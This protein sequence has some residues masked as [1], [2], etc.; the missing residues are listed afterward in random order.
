MATQLDLQTSCKMSSHKNQDFAQCF[1]FTNHFKFHQL[2]GCLHV[3]MDT[4]VI[5]LNV[6]KL[7]KVS[8]LKIHLLQN[9][10]KITLN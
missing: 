5:K 1:D 8:Q 4:N 6:H 9:F 7:Q 2:P 3:I 10:V